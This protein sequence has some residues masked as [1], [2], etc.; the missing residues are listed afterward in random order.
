LRN[1]LP[2][3]KKGGFFIKL[4]SSLILIVAAFFILSCATI[5][6]KSASQTND[7]QTGVEVALAS[8]IE[9]YLED[10]YDYDVLFIIQPVVRQTLVAGVQYY[11]EDIYDYDD[12]FFI[13]QPVI[14]QTADSKILPGYYAVPSIV[15]ETPFFLTEPVPDQTLFSGI[16]YY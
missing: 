15:N 3:F 11:L 12:V 10:I 14:K 4:K 5:G 13:T 16:Q 1:P 9:Y 6:P 7:S 2:S 8:G